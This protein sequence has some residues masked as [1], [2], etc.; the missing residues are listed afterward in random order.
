M[1]VRNNSKVTVI[2]WPDGR[3]EVTQVINPDII[4]LAT[5]AAGATATV[6]SVQ[7]NL[8]ASLRTN[9]G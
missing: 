3:I 7:A 4:K 1:A 9:L 6:V 2:V 5:A 8:P